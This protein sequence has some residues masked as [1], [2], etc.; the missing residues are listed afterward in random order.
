MNTS[1]T[2][3]NVLKSFKLHLGDCVEVMRSMP[4]NSVDLILTDPPYFKVKDEPWDN[5]WAKPAHFLAWLDT[6]LQ[7]FQRVLRPNGSLYLFA[8]P[9][10][11]CRVEM[12]VADRFNVLNSIRWHKADGWHK[13]ARKEDLRSYLNPWEAII[14]AEQKEADSFAY[15]TTEYH[16]AEDELRSRVFEPLRAYLDGERDRAGLSVVDVAEAWRIS[17]GARCRTGL[18][19]H[20]FGAVQWALPTR[21]NYE[22]LRELFGNGSLQREHAELL[23]EYS[24]RKAQ[25]EREREG[26]LSLKQTY[27]DARRPFA[28]TA[29]TPHTD[30]WTFDPVRPYAGK[31]PCEKPAALLEHVITASSRPG[32]VVLDA[33]MGTGSTGVAAVKLGRQFV[34]IE[35]AE[36][37]HRDAATRILAAIPSAANDNTPSDASEATA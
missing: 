20:W 36:H 17:R 8:S 7:E 29:D 27:E 11:A 23:A 24:Q 26:L 31:H 10:M 15:C 35:M 30:L 13:K 5:Q 19:G 14:F 6:V 16:T 33:F 22:W 2:S 12:L 28:V 1:S 25:F 9:Q 32:A 3:G 34:G 4:D 37:H 18:A 21:Q